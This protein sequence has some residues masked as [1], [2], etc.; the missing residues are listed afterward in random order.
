[1]ENARIETNKH[2]IN[3]LET[4]IGFIV[5]STVLDFEKLQI[6]I[7]KFQQ[8]EEKDL[9]LINKRLSQTKEKVKL[10]LEKFYTTKNLI[11]TEESKLSQLYCESLNENLE[12]FSIL[13]KIE[14]NYTDIIKNNPKKAKIYLSEFLQKT[15]IKIRI[16]NFS[17]YSSYNNKNE[18]TYI[19]NIL[20]DLIEEAELRIKNFDSEIN[21]E[22][23]IES[24][25]LN[26]LSMYLNKLLSKNSTQNE[27]VSVNN[28]IKEL[29]NKKNNHYKNIKLLE[30]KSNQLE[31]KAKEL[32]TNISLSKSITQ[33]LEGLIKR[34]NYNSQI[35]IS[36]DRGKTSKKQNNSK[37]CKKIILD[38]IE[39]LKLKLESNK[40]KSELS[41]EFF[42]S[43]IITI[44]NNPVNP[45][46]L[47]SEKI[48]YNHVDNMNKKN[49]SEL[50]QT[51]SVT[52][53]KYAH[54]VRAINSDVSNYNMNKP[55]IKV[56]LNIENEMTGKQFI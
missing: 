11:I 17:S 47:V 37:E 12:I 15:D 35:P 56:N 1:M 19:L 40:N 52:I 46:T 42:Q 28:T 49:I 51:K 29:E 53:N 50:F 5:E 9:Q 22:K 45:K 41:N 36:Y 38:H 6:T 21:I 16:E 24:Y 3:Y 23:E 7:F 34:S 4:L 14:E 48:N 32:L 8:N 44:S 20:K 55:Y 10:E 54:N 25:P 30:I 33:I 31:I 18:F 27:V 39:N 43:S 13:K 26:N 2:S